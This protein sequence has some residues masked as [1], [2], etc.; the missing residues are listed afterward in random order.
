MA[1]RNL[2]PSLWSGE[3]NVVNP[4]REITRLQRRMEHLFD[5][6]LI[7]PT[8]SL[9]RVKGEWPEL[10]GEFVP[11][12]D[13]N[14]TDTHFMVSFDLP[15]VKKEEIKIECRDQ[16]L[17]VSGERK[18]E[19]REEVKGRLTEERF[20]GNFMRS[21]TL[22]ANVNFDQAEARF[23]DGVLQIALPKVEVAPAKQIP[24]KEGKML[25]NKKEI[26]SEKAA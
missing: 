21:F 7:E 5:D 1:I 23:E 14:E 15:G 11:P 4:F 22:P 17:M 10:V 13:V 3:R 12:C 16:V 18:K 20:S 2:L 6:L 9:N 26:K 24:I 19:K 8:Q 25:L